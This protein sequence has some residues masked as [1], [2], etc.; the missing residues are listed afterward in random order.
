MPRAAESLP[1]SFT[2]YQRRLSLFLS[3][4]TFF[5]GYDLIAITQV[6]PDLHADFALSKSAGGLLVAAVNIGAVAAWLLVRRADRWGRRRLLAWTIAGY[7]VLAS[8][9]AWRRAGSASR[10]PSSWRGCSCWASE[11]WP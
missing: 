4:A 7:T 3:V 9:P 6:L 1:T 8:P 11:P 2:P 10:L 5:E